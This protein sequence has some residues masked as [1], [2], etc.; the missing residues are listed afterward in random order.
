MD[1]PE[2]EHR[3]PILL[4]GAWF[5][6]NKAFR[7]RIKNLGITTAQY[8]TLRCLTENNEVT[9][10]DLTELT[11]SNKN[12][13]SSMVK[14]LISLGLVSKKNHPQD[15]R[16]SIIYITSKG[17]E[18]YKMASEE[19]E[20]LRQNVLKNCTSVEESQLVEIL[21]KCTDNL[22]RIK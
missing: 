15:K 12:N 16:K 19:A 21:Q 3:F 13:V 4:R 1:F 20:S 11:S 9:Q 22:S 7:D 10:E 8:T 14:R 18:V 17:T 2:N 5:G 6:M